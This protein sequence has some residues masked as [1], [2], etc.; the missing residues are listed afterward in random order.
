MRFQC[1][2][3][4][5]F[6]RKSDWKFYDLFFMCLF[7]IEMKR[8]TKRQI[9]IETE[10]ILKSQFGSTMWKW[11]MCEF[12]CSFALSNSILSLSFERNEYSAIVLY[13]IGWTIARNRLNNTVM[14]IGIKFNSYDHCWPIEMGLDDVRQRN[15]WH[16]RDKDLSMISIVQYSNQNSNSILLSN[17]FTHSIKGEK[18]KQI[19]VICKSKMLFRVNINIVTF[20]K[21]SS[22]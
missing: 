3:G 17:Q 5:S 16:N 9:N 2:T 1:K 18:R 21:S 10:S 20:W 7:F 14:V 19:I 4:T 13:C 15:N 12:D 6:R 22:V 8:D 11:I